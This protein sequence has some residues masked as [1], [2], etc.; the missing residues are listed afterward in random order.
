[1]VHPWLAHH[2]IRA[3]TDHGVTPVSARVGIPITLLADPLCFGV[4]YGVAGEF[5]AGAL[6]SI[7]DKPTTQCHSVFLRADD[8]Y[9][10]WAGDLL[11]SNS[12]QMA[13]RPDL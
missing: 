10:I 12:L 13:H 4:P 11:G 2:R 6:V 8:Y 3:V 1:M 9:R 7:H 5:P